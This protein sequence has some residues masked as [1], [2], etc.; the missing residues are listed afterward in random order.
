MSWNKATIKLDNGETIIAQAPHI[1][2]AS[3]STDIPAFYAD[4]FFHR[5]NIGYSAWINPFNGKKSYISYCNTRFIVF[6]SKNPK[7]LFPYIPILKEKKI[8]FYIQYTL[9][10]YETEQL[11]MGVPPKQERIETFREFSRILGKESVIWRFDPMILTDTITINTLLKKVEKLGDT[12]HNYTEKL[13]FSYADITSYKKVKS[14]LEKSKVQYVEWNEEQMEEFASRLS[15]LNERKGWGLQLATCAEKLDASKYGIEHN[16]CI[17]GDLIVR[18]AWKDPR[19]MDILGVKIE[20][21]PQPNLFNESKIPQNAI[22]LLDNH[23]FL[24]IHKKDKGQRKLC[25]CMVAKDIGE[26]NTCPHLCE[27]CYA[28]ANKQIAQKNYEMHK[29]NPLSDT[30]QGIY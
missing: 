25:D 1:I 29:C 4:W 8:N 30:I 19:L 24:S 10:D 22:L 28:N 16:R 21:M 17:D 13:V 9:N 3:R 18:L 15:S 2:S 7:P 12:L 27:Y 20:N 6:W 23:Y 14:N 11:E 26:Y 5:L